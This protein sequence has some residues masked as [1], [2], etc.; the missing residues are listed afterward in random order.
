ML[1][2]K[3]PCKNETIIQEI[4]GIL[5]SV[6]AWEKVVTNNEYF[7]SVEFRLFGGIKKLLLK[8]LNLFVLEI[9]SSKGSNLKT[10]VYNLNSIK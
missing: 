9:V 4:R 10:Y 8:T 6:F 2:G 1:F 5:L 3:E 7:E